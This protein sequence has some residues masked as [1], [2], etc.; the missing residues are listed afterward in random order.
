M[1]YTNI[2][3]YDGEDYFKYVLEYTRTNNQVEV[4]VEY[5]DGVQLCDMYS[6]E[7]VFLHDDIK[8]IKHHN[9]WHQIE[10]SEGI[11]AHVPQICD[12]ATLRLYFPQFSVDTYNKG[13]K[14]AITA[15]TWICGKHIILGSYIINRH[16]ALACAGMKTFFNEQYYEYIDLDIIDPKSLMYSDDWSEWRKEVCG[17]KSEL[18]LINSVGSVLHVTLHPVSILE[19]EYVELYGYTGGQ[20]SINLTSD[21]K[22]YLSLDITPNIKKSLFPNL[23]PAIDFK[24]NFNKFYNDSLEDY[25]LETY[26]VRN[27]KI[28]YELVIGNNEDIYTVLTSPVLNLTTSYK[29]IKDEINAE[30]F[31]NRTGWKSGIDIVGSVDI[32]NED[33][34]S[35]LYLLSNRIPFSEELYKYF[36]RTDFIDNYGYTIN[37][38][39]LDDVDMN[40]LNIN[41]IS[42]TENKIIKIDRADNNKANIY[43]TKFYRVVDSTQIVIRPEINENVCINLDMYKHLVESFILQIEGIKFVEI[44]RLK[45]GVVFKVIGNRLPKKINQGQYYILNQDYDLVTSG[46]YIYEA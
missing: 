8:Y 2:N 13:H 4:G 39:N 15:S 44:G 24:L 32:L 27:C 18:E 20:S 42:K 40:V 25:L 16:D 41:A 36:I 1:S 9:H 31:G 37:H 38:V 14:Y 26:G 17:E 10:Y 12:G 21:E 46:K 11:Q 5:L 22:D 19:G 45:T 43:Q 33:G 34:E 35:I 6:D 30:N 29:F 23:R 7:V 3:I 28:K